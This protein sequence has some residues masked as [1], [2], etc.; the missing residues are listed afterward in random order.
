MT[1]TTTPA[2]AAQQA[3]DFDLPGIDDRRWTLA[4]VRGARGGVIVFMCN[5]CPYV[6]AITERLEAVARQLR[7]LDIGMAGINANDAVSYPEDSFEAMKV[8]GQQFSFPYL[9]DADQSVA[10]A[11]G[12]V[13]TPDFFGFNAESVVCYRGRLD[14]SGIQPATDETSPELLEAMTLIAQTGAGPAEQYPSMGC[15]I[16]WL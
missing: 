5:H 8:F 6:Q 3:P 13:C 4:Q 1:L 16:K 9:H 2:A 15:S 10:R 7:A 12:A 11:Y 14:S